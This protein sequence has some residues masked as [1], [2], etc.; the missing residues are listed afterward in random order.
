MGHEIHPEL[1]ERIASLATVR[2]DELPPTL[3]ETALAEGEGRLAA[4]GALAVTTGIYTGRSVKDKFIVRDA[5]TEHRVWWDN[6]QAM[7]REHFDLLLGDMLAATRGRI[8]HGQHLLA[9]ADLARTT[10]LQAHLSR[11]RQALAELT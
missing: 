1:A 9:G 6:S 10:E 3:V 5:E 11:V 7:T 8:L 2:W 4:G